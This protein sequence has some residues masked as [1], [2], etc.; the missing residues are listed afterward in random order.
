[1]KTLKYILIVAS[2][3]VLLT[4]CSKDDDGGNQPLQTLLSKRITSTETIS[5]TYDN[6][7]RATGYST[8][9]ISPENN[10]IV[11]YNYHSSGQLAEVIYNPANSIEDT[12]VVYSY[13]NNNQIS[14]IETSYVSGSLSSP[15]S[16]YEADYS[17][18]GKVSVFRYTMA[19]TGT[20]YLNTE[21]YLDAN[22]NVESQLSY[23]ASGL[24]IVTTE[25]SNYDDKKIASASL[26]DEDFVRPINNYGTVT[27]TATGSAP[28]VS[29]FT[30]E[31][32]DDGYPTKRTS[33]T[34]SMVT[35]EY[36]KR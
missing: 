18:P 26:P 14:R 9:N 31:Y 34:G 35:Y 16:K 11:T 4:S 24:L 10:F 21:Y 5:Y 36:I 28:S 1:M 19:G 17:T 7:N 15:V 20:P 22:G 8:E 12:K 6:N 2:W 30:Y 3:L 32:N 25:N 33:N 23:S 27:V 13:N 29:T